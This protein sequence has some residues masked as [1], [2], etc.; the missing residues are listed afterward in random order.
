[1]MSRFSEDAVTSC[2][3]N[4]RSKSA[5]LHNG[6]IDTK[7]INFGMF[8][9]RKDTRGL[10]CIKQQCKIHKYARC[11]YCKLLPYIPSCLGREQTL[12]FK[13]PPTPNS[14]DMIC[15]EGLEVLMF[16]IEKLN[17][18]ASGMLRCSSSIKTKT[19]VNSQPLLKAR[20]QLARMR[21]R[22]WAREVMGYF[23][24]EG[25]TKVA[26]KNSAIALTSKKQTNSSNHP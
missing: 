26:H 22:P 12:H 18:M 14:H 9:G 5:F 16:G 10:R 24:N 6:Q 13:M 2:L 8:K 21:S 3:E 19:F 20:A 7:I 1:M 4:L 23:D 25:P 17:S 11:T 15:E